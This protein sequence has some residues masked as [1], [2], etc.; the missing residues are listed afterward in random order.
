MAEADG[1]GRRLVAVLPDQPDLRA[2]DGVAD[3]QAHQ[4]AIERL[5]PGVE[6]KQVVVD[7]EH[8]QDVGMAALR[9]LLQHGEIDGVEEGRKL[10][11]AGAQR[12]DTAG[13]GRND[14]ADHLVQVR[15]PRQE[16]VRVA[17]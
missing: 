16:V 17:H 3:G 11:L 13:I 2:V 4:R 12:R 10:N 8:V 5:A 14:L 7:V 6:A 9:Q 15:Q 1:V